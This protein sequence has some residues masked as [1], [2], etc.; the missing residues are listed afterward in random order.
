MDPIGTVNGLV[1]DGADTFGLA[2]FWSG[3]S[4]P[5]STRTRTTATTST[6]TPTDDGLTLRFQRVPEAKTVK[7]RLHLDIEVADVEAAVERGSSRSAGRSSAAPTP[8]T[9]GGS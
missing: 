2:A 5:R 3:C 1:I 6:C 4:R 7:N 9:A 8:S